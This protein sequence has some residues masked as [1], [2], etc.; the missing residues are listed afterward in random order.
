MG[1]LSWSGSLRALPGGPH[2]AHAAA[3][4]A[5]AASPGQASSQ[6]AEAALQPEPPPGGASGGS[7]LSRV[8]A[9]GQVP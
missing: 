2:C 5:G 4:H 1:P 7:P 8:P 3:T 9:A 6:Q